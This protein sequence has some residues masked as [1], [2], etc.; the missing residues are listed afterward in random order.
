[1]KVSK[2]MYPTNEINFEIRSVGYRRERGE[3]RPEDSKEEA[4]RRRGRMAHIILKFNWVSVPGEVNTGAN[5]TRRGPPGILGLRLCTLPHAIPTSSTF[6]PCGSRL[7]ISRHRPLFTN[8]TYF[9]HGWSS[10]VKNLT[11][12]APFSPFVSQVRSD[13]KMILNV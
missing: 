2:R 10:G 8:T 11:I 12:V 6:P 3:N 7:N 9:L 5:L 4:E 1:M 13:D